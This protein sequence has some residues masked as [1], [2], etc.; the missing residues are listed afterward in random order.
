MIYRIAITPGEPAGIGPDILLRVAQQQ[1]S[2]QLIAIADP[3]ILEKRAKQ[4]GLPITLITFD[5]TQPPVISEPGT[6]H[7][8]PVKANRIPKPGTEDP[9]N[10]SYVLS[11]LIQATELCQKKVINALV[12]GPINKH[13]INKG[14]NNHS[15]PL[16]H[17]NKEHFTGHTEFLAKLTN[18][19]RVVMMLTNDSLTKE[20]KPL[21]VA[22]ATTHLPLCDVSN[23]ITEALLEET[24]QILN[25]D[26]INKFGIHRPRILVCG[27][28]PHAGEGGDLGSEEITIINPCISRLR[29]QGID[30]SNALPADTLFTEKY[31]KTADAVLAMYHDQGLPVLKSQSFGSAVNITLGLPIIRTSV[32]HGT[33]FDL[34]GT[35]QADAG[36]MQA[37]INCANNLVTQSKF[38]DA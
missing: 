8:I 20:N 14:L 6:L 10:A 30:L 5:Q 29:K 36:S 27:L 4:I 7:I 32:D 19:P 17:S 18:T 28:N 2:A 13:L 31:L 35:G 33:A 3:L 37:A 24:I 34:A 15:S 1:Q 22:L 21:R 16:A 26:L 11:T 9:D 12:T 38:P 23:T 25:N